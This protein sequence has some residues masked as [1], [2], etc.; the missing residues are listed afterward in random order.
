MQGKVRGNV[1]QGKRQCEARLE[2]MGG[3]VRG[4]VKQGKRQWEA[5]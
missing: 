5:R 1:R 2:A 4:N 3:K